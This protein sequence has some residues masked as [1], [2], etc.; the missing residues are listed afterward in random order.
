MKIKQGDRRKDKKK[1]TD[2]LT[3]AVRTALYEVKTVDGEWWPTT[4][5]WMSLSDQC[6]QIANCIWQTWLVWHVQNDS[7]NKLRVWLN[8]LAEASAE[9]LVE[10]ETEKA[11]S[12]SI[13]KAKAKK[14]VGPSPVE[15]VPNE[16]SKLIYKTLTETFPS[17]HTRVVTLIQNSI[18][19]DIKQH[20][21][22]KGSLPGWSAVLLCHQQM[23]SS[24]KPHPIPFDKSNGVIEPPSGKGKNFKIRLKQWR[25]HIE[26][27]T[28]AAS[29]EDT[30]ELRCTGR[31]VQSQVAIL[32]RIVSG[33][34]S[35]R[36]SK[37]FYN[38][39]ERKWFVALC[40]RMPARLMPKLDADKVAVIRPSSAMPWRLLLPDVRTTQ[41]IGGRGD[42]I[43]PTRQRIFLQR[44]NR[45]GNYIYANSNAKGHGRGRAHKWRWKLQRRWN[46]FVKRCNHIVSAKTVG[47]CVDR[48]VG[49]LIY[50]KPIGARAES[51][52][53]SKSGKFGGWRDATTWQYQQ[54][55]IFLKYKCKRAGIEF[56]CK[57]SEVL[58]PKVK[59]SKRVA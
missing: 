6:K 34:Y 13:A 32:E 50:L 29:V 47:I 11:I 1:K 4:K 2:D 30:L 56:V 42:Y 57:E 5:R 52:F 25:V 46:D 8:K 53:L 15:P 51:R 33:E 3:D 20:K 40:Y 19:R 18:V 28:F 36:G 17:A 21:A 26:G 55:E 16:L 23:P 39:S 7:A 22:S 27:K 49:K 45:S 14:K 37:L 38:P 35:F 41:W 59:K 44:R 10:A 54:V 48:G 58:S 31:K 12:N 24:T 9:A 43:A